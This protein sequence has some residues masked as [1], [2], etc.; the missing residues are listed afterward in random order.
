MQPRVSQ[1]LLHLTT[2]TC[3]ATPNLSST[4]IE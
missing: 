4:S 1:E 2:E 3:R